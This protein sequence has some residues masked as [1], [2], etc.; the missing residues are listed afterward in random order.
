[1]RTLVITPGPRRSA[2]PRAYALL[3][4]AEPS[5]FR[6]VLDDDWYSDQPKTSGQPEID[7]WFVAEAKRRKRFEAQN[8]LESDTPYERDIREL[9]WDVSEKDE[10]IKLREL[11]RRALISLAR[12]TSE[13]ESPLQAAMGAGAIV[14]PAETWTSRPRAWKADDRRWKR[15][16]EEIVERYRGGHCIV[17]ATCRPS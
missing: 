6:C 15:Q 9:K 4:E 3:N 2:V 17:E 11:E 13:L 16:V 7:A 10:R 12:L 1:M 14:T 8:P 5:G